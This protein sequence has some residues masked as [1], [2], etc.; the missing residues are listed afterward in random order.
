MSQA[1]VI[2]RRDCLRLA[3]SLGAAPLLGAVAAP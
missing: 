1:P 3:A 2:A